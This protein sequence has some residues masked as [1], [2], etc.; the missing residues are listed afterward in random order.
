M[1]SSIKLIAIMNSDVKVDFSQYQQYIDELIFATIAIYSDIIFAVSQLSSYNSNLCQRHL[2]A[3]KHVLRYLKE[4]INLDIVYKSQS[5]SK[6]PHG[7]WSN[8]I[9]LFDVD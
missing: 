3:T 9:E 5:I 4:I 8:E 1:N 6:S 2:T 7:F